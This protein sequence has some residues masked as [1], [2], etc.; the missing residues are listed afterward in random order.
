M[1]HR[2][3]NAVALPKSALM[4]PPLCDGDGDGVG[5]DAAAATNGDDDDDND[6]GISST[7]IGGGERPRRQATRHDNQP[8][9]R[10]ATRGRGVMRGGGKAKAPDNVMQ[11][12]AMQQPTNGEALREA[13]APAERVREATGQHNNQLNKW[14]AIARQKVEVPAEGFGKAERAAYKRQR[15]NE[16]GAMTTTT[17]L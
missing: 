12:D 16:S 6:S 15:R 10:G 14:G 7:A 3:G 17:I 13:G 4:A 8:N 5:D 1:M 11:L 2:A 9:K